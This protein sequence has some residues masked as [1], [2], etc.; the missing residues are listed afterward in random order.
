MAELAYKDF[1][2]PIINIFKHLKDN[3]IIMSEEIGHVTKK[4]ATVKNENFRTESE[5]LKKLQNKNEKQNMGT[6]H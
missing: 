5:T 1:R 2:A 3:I 4:M 6:K